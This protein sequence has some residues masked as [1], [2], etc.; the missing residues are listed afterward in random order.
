MLVAHSVKI[1]GLTS[2]NWSTASF[3]G[4]KLLLASPQGNIA[5][6]DVVAKKKVTSNSAARSDCQFTPLAA[7]C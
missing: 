5:V 6:Y 3:A 4:N 7:F 2:E 1:N